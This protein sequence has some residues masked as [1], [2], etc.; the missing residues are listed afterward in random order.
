[1]KTFGLL[2]ALVWLF[3]LNS[4]AQQS[5]NT[6]KTAGQYDLYPKGKPAPAENFTGSVWVWPLVAND[7]VFH[8]VSG[9]VTFAPGARSHWHAH[10]AGQIL[11]I[12]GGTCYYQEKGGTI[13]VF[14]KGDVIKCPPNIDHWH[15]ASPADTMTHIALNPNTQNGIVVWKQEVTDKEYRALKR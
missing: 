1:M 13:Q 6:D 11:Y 14:H 4:N 12:T 8:F 5:A 10:P 2:I 15:G 9:S 7:S 3:S